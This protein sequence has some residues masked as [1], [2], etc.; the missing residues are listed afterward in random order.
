MYAGSPHTPLEC[1]QD[2]VDISLGI[3]VTFTQFH[4]HLMHMLEHVT[5]KT[6]KRVFN[7]LT[8]TPAV[9]DYLALHYGITYTS[10]PRPTPQS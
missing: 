1:L 10:I 3:G 6:E 8:S 5:T 2:W 7:N 9:L 4:Q